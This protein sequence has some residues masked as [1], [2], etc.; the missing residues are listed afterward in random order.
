MTDRMDVIKMTE[1]RSWHFH[2]LMSVQSFGDLNVMCPPHHYVYTT[3]SCSS[4]SSSSREDWVPVHGIYCHPIVTSCG[5]YCDVIMGAMASQITSPTIVCSNVYSGAD[6]RKHQSSAS[7][8]FVRGIHR[9]PVN[10]PPKWPVTLKMFPFGDVIMSGQNRVLSGFER[11]GLRK[12]S[13]CVK[14]YYGWH[15]KMNSYCQSYRI[16]SIMVY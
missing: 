6:Q 8:A 10:S 11:F 1:D 14:C 7:L 5:H 4:L 13:S 15:I 9:W 2:S 3:L 12:D 16:T